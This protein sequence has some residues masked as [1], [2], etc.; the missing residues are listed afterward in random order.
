M[1]RKI[2]RLS[3]ARQEQLFERLMETSTVLLS[4]RNRQEMLERILQAVQESGFDRARLF[5][6]N[7]DKTT[8]RG[9]AQVG[10]DAGCFIGVEWSVA[11]DCYFQKLLADPRPHIFLYEQGR[12]EHSEA[13]L[14]KED[15]EVWVCVPLLLRGKVIGHISADNK[16]SRRT[17]PE[18]ELAPLALFT[19]QAAAAIE[20]A[21]LTEKAERWAQRLEELRRTALTLTQAATA[22]RQT[23]LQTIIA[24]SVA[25]LEAKSG[26]IYELRRSVDEPL[27]AG[28]L[29]LVA[30]HNRSDFVGK[31]LRVGEGVAGHLVLSS[32][33]FRIVRDYNVEPERAAIF[34]A[35]RVFGAVLEVPLRRN[36]TVVGVL[37]VDDEVGREFTPEDARLL[38]FFA[39]QAALVLANQELLAQD[40]AKLQRLEQL[41]RATTEIVGQIGRVP[42]AELL[43]L[44]AQRAREILA[45]EVCSILLVKQPDVLTLEASHGYRPGS[46][47]RGLELPIIKGVGTGLTGHIA[48]LGE[49]CNLHGAALAQHPA[50]RDHAN[51][52]TPSGQCH[53]LLAVPLKQT[54]DGEARL[55]GLLRA[56]NKQGADGLPHATLGFSDEDEWILSIFAEVIVVCLESAGLVAA[57]Q[58]LIANLP[59]ALIV[60]DR[61]GL[62]T[63]VNA[64]AEALSGY[65][66]HELLG[67]PVEQIYYDAA[68][69]RE[70]GRRIHEMDGKLQGYDTVV[71]NKAGQPV[72]IRMTLYW[73]RDEAG[74]RTGS[75]GNFEDLSKLKD[76]EHRLELIQRAIG[77]VAEATDLQAGL[78]GLAELLVSILPGVFC[79]ILLLDETQSCLVTEAAAYQP[80]NPDE[81]AWTPGIGR[82]YPLSDYPRLMRWLDE[83]LPRPLTREDAEIAQHF[84][85]LTTE[86]GL[87]RPL[88]T[89]LAIPLKHGDRLVGL[90][91]LGELRSP[92]RSLF[93]PENIALAEAI[94][95]QSTIQI[96]RSLALQAAE[97]NHAQLQHFYTVSSSLTHIKN[98]KSLLQA[99]IKEACSAAEADGV[100]LVLIDEQERWA[101]PHSF[102][103]NVKL[104]ELLSVR[105]DG[106]SMKV[107]RSG[108]V[109]IIAD[110]SRHSEPLNP[111]LI[112]TAGAAICLPLALPQ[113]RIG[114]MW[115]HYNRPRRFRNAEI[116]ALQ[117]YV[118]QAAAAYENAEQ[119]KRMWQ[120]DKAAKSLAGASE[121]TQVVEQ[122]LRHTRKALGADAAVFWFFDDKYDQF[123]QERSAQSYLNSKLWE[124]HRL[125]GPSKDG[126][127]YRLL[128]QNWLPVNDVAE[129]QAEQK[130]GFNIRSLMAETGMRGFQGIAVKEGAERLG[131]IYALYREPRSFRQMDGIAAITLAN[132]AAQALKKAK[133]IEQNRKTNEAADAVAEITVLGNRHATLKRIVAEV[134]QAI[135]CNA[136]VLFEFDQHSKHLLPPVTI[137]V[138]DEK[139]ESLQERYPLV[140]QILEE[141]SPRIVER[142]KENPDFNQRSFAVIQQ[143][144]SCVA[145][146]LIAAEEK[147]GVLFLNYRKPRRFT[148]EEIETMQLFANQAALAI[149]Y[150]QA[151]E[152]RE[153]E[154]LRQKA[155]VLL[156]SRLRR[157]QTPQEMMDSLVALAAAGLNVEFCNLVLRDESGELIL[158]A[159]FGWNPPIL[160]LRLAPGAGSQTGHTIETEQPVFVD[161]FEAVNPF[162]VHPLVLEAGI[163]SG[164]SVPIIRDGKVVG[165]ILAYTVNQRRFSQTEAD[166]LGAVAN[167]TLRSAEQ[168][169]ALIHR[170][171]HIQAMYQSTH[172][173]L[174]GYGQEQQ[175][176]DEILRAAV[177][178]IKPSKV[179]S[180]DTT[181]V[182]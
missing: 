88:D 61:Q 9:V 92:A 36:G 158:R 89:L 30:Q 35:A 20:Q 78:Q 86:L 110:T 178:S 156:E 100:F 7:A 90:L 139:V 74:R 47:Q 1:K 11:A 77:I 53:S 91:D 24:Q 182:T 46:F 38:S 98:P 55:R 99:I 164:L 51:S 111:T 6:L 165:A 83:G 70:I 128:K 159:Q 50:V 27:T 134:Q 58:Q 107:F 25:L 131:V 121:V 8:L 157:L 167:L 140:E 155:L 119:Y 160:E 95:K 102:T 145:I 54:T 12:P 13:C 150:A 75:V 120:M 130:L 43:T 18:A 93:T 33:P 143:I 63:T 179:A 41:A 84:D 28:E 19:A 166:Y 116:A 52:F 67:K 132:Y 115:I 15:V 149:H 80:S 125:R 48:A 175:V 97:R 103:P 64:Q 39:E 137:G 4:G 44:I 57:Q 127:A 106:I 153:H 129:A 161:D 68:Q 16:H 26:G 42:M 104:G 118:N 32:E 59:H 173:I 138:W 112:R 72:P 81:P 148:A 87:N 49:L 133:L 126:T 10:M 21:G 163:K 60:T 73:S 76:Y 3:A 5:L 23:L 85:R 37:Y 170:D 62:I 45:A 17:I 113:M 169:D 96:D 180:G 162:L 176:L 168:R 174:S 146:P 114:V 56:D 94:A 122:M 79:A 69:P 109:E 124:P 123:I 177:E 66:A 108:A 82:S 135:G 71:P 40:E 34:G 105:P 101:N 136:V 147:F 171:E 172:A 117:L 142:L 22:Q 181:A 154:L 14:D 141:D 151:T 65:S 2:P 152:L 144:E 29:V 31:V